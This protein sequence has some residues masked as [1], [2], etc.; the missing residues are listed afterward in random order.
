MS[1]D[2]LKQ[3]VGENII[4]SARLDNICRAIEILMTDVGLP[5]VD[6]A[7]VRRQLWDGDGEQQVGLVKLVDSSGT[8]VTV[9]DTAHTDKNEVMIEVEG[10]II[11]L[12]IAQAEAL[13]EVLQGWIMT[14]RVR[15][16]NDI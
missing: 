10:E 12:G 4:L 7:A 14:G 8:I 2:I 15:S 11:V 16:G 3:L 1:E 9:S 6:K 5:E 13:R